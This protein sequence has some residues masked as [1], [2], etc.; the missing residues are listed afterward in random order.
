MNSEDFEVA[1]SFIAKETFDSKRL[2]IAKNIVKNN[3][4]SSKQIASICRLFTYDSNRVE[5]AKFAYPSCIDKGMYFL[6]DATFTYSSSREELH[7]YLSQY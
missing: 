5:F 6:L 1:F 2:E 4:V 3:W 7:D